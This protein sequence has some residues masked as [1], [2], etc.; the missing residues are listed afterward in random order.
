MIKKL[1]QIELADPIIQQ[2]CLVQLLDRRIKLEEKCKA[3]NE[4]QKSS[5]GVKMVK[6]NLRRLQSSSTTLNMNISPRPLEKPD[7]NAVAQL[8]AEC[9]PHLQQSTKGQSQ[10]TDPDYMEC[11]E[12][13][14]N[15]LKA[16]RNWRLLKEIFG[17]GI[18]LLVPC[19]IQTNR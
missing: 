6:Y 13:L 17:I 15:R 16:A 7:S 19:D 4:V 2:H 8:M 11:K 18:L 14:Q 5:R 3:E 1:D 10:P 12:R 9:Y